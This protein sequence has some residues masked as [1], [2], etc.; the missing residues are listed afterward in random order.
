MNFI[1]RKFD[2]SSLTTSF[3]FEALLGR[4]F[5][6]FF[7]E[8]A[9]AALCLKVVEDDMVLFFQDLMTLEKLILLPQNLISFE[10]TL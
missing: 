1:L 7:R 6:A 8:R 10:K 9:L 4:A 2:A 3:L 5:L